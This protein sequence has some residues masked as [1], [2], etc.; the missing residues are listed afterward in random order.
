MPKDWQVL[1]DQQPVGARQPGKLWKS[2]TV[3]LEHKV[4]VKEGSKMR[5]ER[6][7]SP[8]PAV[9]PGEQGLILRARKARQG[10]KQVGACARRLTEAILELSGDQQATVLDLGSS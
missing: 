3:S 9:S 5:L 8:R 7:A 6:W 10:V 4:C 2:H 1:T